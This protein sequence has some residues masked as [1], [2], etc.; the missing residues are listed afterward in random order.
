[1]PW[2]ES[3]RSVCIELYTWNPRAATSEKA[4]HMIPSVMTPPAWIMVMTAATRTA[5][6]DPMALTTDEVLRE[7]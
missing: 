3:L 7:T 5:T 1:M 6:M 2:M 4:D